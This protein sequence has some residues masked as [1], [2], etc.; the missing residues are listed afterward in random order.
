MV[1]PDDHSATQLRVAK[2]TLMYPQHAFKPED[3]LNFF[4]LPQFTKRWE[5]LG[6]DD[7]DDLLAL[8]LLIMTGPKVVGD[9]IEGTVGLRK[10]RFGRG[11][12]GKSGGVRVLYVYFEEFGIVLLCLV[13]AKSEISSI[14]DEVK[15]RLNGI[16]RQQHEEFRRRFR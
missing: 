3:L 11:D 16:I 5:K 10:M 13:Y 2:A 4:E 15:K 12:A 7:E 1:N 8:Q 6:F 14:S 9:V